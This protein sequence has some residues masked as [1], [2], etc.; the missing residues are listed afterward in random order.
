M[1]YCYL[2]F[3]SALLMYACFLAG[4]TA[5]AQ[6]YKQSTA[7][8]DPHSE[9]GVPAVSEQ[10]PRVRFKKAVSYDSGGSYANWVVVGDLNGDGHPDLV[11]ANLVGSG[12]NYDC[13]GSL[14]VLL[15]NGDG[16]FQSAVA[17]D[18]GGPNTAAVAI[19][20]VNGDGY[21]DLVVANEG[22]NNNNGSVS[23][24]L[25]NGDGTFQSP[26][27]YNA[28]DGP[29]SI[30]LADLRGIGVLDAIVV[31]IDYNSPVE[32]SV[33]LGNGDGTFQPPMG[34][35][36]L[37][38]PIF[39][40]VGDVNG[41][42]RPDLVL[43]CG[44]AYDNMAVLL[45]NGD[46]TFQSPMIYSSG[47]QVPRSVAIADLNG[48]GYPDLAVTNQCSETCQNEN[49][50]PPVGVLFG[51]GDGTFQSPVLYSS[52][53][54]DSDSIAIADVNGDGYPDLIVANQDTGGLC[55]GPPEVTLLVG[56]GDG[57][58]PY[59]AD[60][61]AGEGAAVSVANA[62]LRGDIRTDIVTANSYWN[63]VAVLLNDLSFATTTALTSSPNPSQINQP[64]ALT[65]TITSSRAI[66][67]GQAITFYNGK[68]SLGTA[69]TTNGAATLS[70]VFSKAG[71]FTIKARYAGGD[72]LAASSATLK[73]VV[74]R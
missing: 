39:V 40:T 27:N 20:D 3:S 16:T 48:D 31:D 59:H 42:G 24:L 34:Y 11:V 36:G 51:N 44:G 45:G 50:P 25:G 54:C 64:V 23:V 2:V 35:T 7:L 13:D 29:A 71:T 8:T 55:G 57:T 52:H 41:D 33:L 6:T 70:T 28:G 66:P 74:E 46:G 73:Q 43:T 18:S 65:A 17:Y 47:G 21:S 32:L 15:G 69:A 9:L 12:C 67:D 68:V 56:D 58:F 1:K 5:R 60:Y 61:L 62:D 63:T 14:G 38:Q 22:T 10:A 4:R 19:G 37:C 49:S 30:R 72:Y 26:V 53:G